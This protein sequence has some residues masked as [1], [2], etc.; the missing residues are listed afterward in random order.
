MGGFG[1]FYKGEKKKQK[2]DQLAKKAGVIGSFYT[3]PKIEILGKK[4]KKSY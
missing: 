2:K 4:G 3:P 1:S